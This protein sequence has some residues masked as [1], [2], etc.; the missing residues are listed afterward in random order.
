MPKTVTL[1]LPTIAFSERWRLMLGVVLLISGL[2]VGFIFWKD[3]YVFARY[4]DP[5]LREVQR[6]LLD[7]KNKAETPGNET[8]G[9]ATVTD[10]TKINQ[11]GVLKNAQ[12]G[13]KVLLFYTNGEALL[14]R[15]SSSKVVAIGPLVVDPSA[16][17]VK[18]TKIIVR[19][20]TSGGDKYE[21]ILSMLKE[22]YK[23]AIISGQ[24]SAS[25]DDFPMTIAIDLTK[26]GK[27]AEFVSAINELIDGRNGILPI[28]EEKPE[29]DILIIVGND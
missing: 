9:L 28:G 3:V 1:S 4:R 22:R 15:P 12:N 6:L 29:S 19:N 17:Q 20:G 5:D 18:D 10:R 16:A 2:L 8:P 11:G 24:D 7:I 27:K 23:G 13:D 21:R 25:R 26:D 14:Y